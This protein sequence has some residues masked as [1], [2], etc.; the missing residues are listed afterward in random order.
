M[1]AC[2]EFAVEYSLPTMSTASDVVS[3][4]NRELAFSRSLGILTP[5]ELKTL[6]GKTVAIAGLG[7]VGGSHLLTLTRLGIGG[8]HLAD[9]DS[10]ALENFNRHAGANM[11]SIGRPKLDVM[12]EAARQINPDLRI[13]RFP[14][15]V[16]SDNIE[17]FLEGV[18]IYVDS[19]DYFAFEMRAL[20]FKTCYAKNIPA[21]TAGP[22]GMGS[23]L[24]NFMPGKM[25][26]AKY[27]NWT[28]GDSDYDKAIKF[29][30]GLAPSLPHRHSLSDRRYV[31]LHEK[32][33]PSTPMGVELCAGFA[34]T[35]VLKILLRRGRVRAAPHS[36]HFDAFTNRFYSRRIWGGNRNPL[37]RLKI[38]FVKKVFD[39][40]SGPKL[41]PAP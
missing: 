16:T 4:F 22:L 35:E 39:K 33:G 31:D 25:T 3:D 8:F 17:S 40:K 21:V 2:S 30:V 36:Q 13:R 26:F 12:E 19:I 6:A 14:E 15:G 11:S 38:A 20:L 23:A 32:R 37:Q 41:L 18:D 29:L 27:F 34:C 24:L 7:G 5:D 1:H 28:K 10:F 9:F